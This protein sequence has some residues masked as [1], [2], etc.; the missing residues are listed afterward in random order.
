MNYI[1]DFYL[2]LAQ[3]TQILYYTDYYNHNTVKHFLEFLLLLNDRNP[4]IFF[5]EEWVPCI[6]IE[7]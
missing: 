4:T 6:F 3:W 1:H 2:Y 7:N 5:A